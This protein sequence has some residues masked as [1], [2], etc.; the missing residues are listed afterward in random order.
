MLFKSVG[1]SEFELIRSCV[2]LLHQA[3]LPRPMKGWPCE[4][5]GPKPF[6]RSSNLLVDPG[7]I[8]PP[9][10]TLE[11]NTHSLV[12]CSS[13]F[14]RDWRAPSAS[15][16]VFASCGT[17]RVNWADSYSALIVGLVCYAN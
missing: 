1:S 7:D 2:D 9:H 13:S 10:L 14:R 17:N 4:T 16:I 15:H 3:F 5:S 8:C 12:T 11:N 6:A